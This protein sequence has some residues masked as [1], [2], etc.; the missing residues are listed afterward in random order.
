MPNFS[1]RQFL[2]DSTVAISS[3]ACLFTSALEASPWVDLGS[4]IAD[5]QIKDILTE[6]VAQQPIPGVVAAVAE[7]GKELRIACAGKRKQGSKAPIL[8]DDVMHMGSCTK[9]MTAT[10]IGRLVDQKR[11]SFSSTIEEVLP[12][13]AAK[14]HADY[15]G[16]TLAN[17]LT[18]RSGMP[19]NAKNWWLQDGTTI[20][21]KRLNVAVDSLVAPPNDKP[22]EDYLYS[23]LGYMVA[24][25]MAVTTGKKSWE[26]LITAQVFKPL[27][28]DSAGFGVPGTSGEVDQPWGHISLPGDRI[29]AVQGDNAAALGP[30]GTAHMSVADWAKFALLHSI[31]Q[32]DLEKLAGSGKKTMVGGLL[33]PETMLTLHTP[34]QP[35]FKTQPSHAMGWITGQRPW[36]AGEVLTHSGTNTMWYCTVWLAPIQNR[37]YLVAAN[38]SGGQTATL[39]D[40]LFGPLIQAANS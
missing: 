32:A 35:S 18:H 12:N 15:R 27:G 36:A 8:I 10:L 19:A 26:E 17:L 2:Q 34:I 38:I 40:S 39:V 24:G 23:N 31:S 4:Q 16:V 1:R 5:P 14:I 30:A 25:L 3:A 13:L 28:M 22:S 20:T 29:R 7:K 11:L 21:Q 37:A 33:T 9:A 6:M